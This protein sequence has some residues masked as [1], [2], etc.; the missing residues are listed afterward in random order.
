MESNQIPGFTSMLFPSPHIKVFYHQYDA[1]VDGVTRCHFQVLNFTSKVPSSQEHFKVPSPRFPRICVQLGCIGWNGP[2]ENLI[3]LKQ[4]DILALVSKH[5]TCWAN[6]FGADIV[7]NRSNTER[8]KFLNIYIFVTL[9]VS[10][11]MNFLELDHME[12]VV[13]LSLNCC[14]EHRLCLS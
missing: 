3:W 12:K 6:E 8:W 13:R 2:E 11:A 10:S 14:W 7:G 4:R 1:L 9:T 5:T